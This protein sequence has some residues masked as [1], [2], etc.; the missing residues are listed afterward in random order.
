MPSYYAV[1]NSGQKVR[2][3]QRF[4]LGLLWTATSGAI[5]QSQ[6]K[7]IHDAWGTRFHPDSL[8]IEGADLDAQF[9]V[10]NESMIL[11]A[12]NQDLLGQ[13]LSINYNL[14]GGGLKKVTFLPDRIRVVINYPGHFMEHLPLLVAPDQSIKIE[15]GTIVHLGKVQFEFNGSQV[16]IVESTHALSASKHIA[17]IEV[18]AQNELI[19]EVLF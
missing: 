17:L 6:T 7:S 9:I 13:N 3:Q 4:G 18:K 15:K 2:D 11:K 12:G 16:S 1:F 14:G 8:P 10:D 5:L 19:Y